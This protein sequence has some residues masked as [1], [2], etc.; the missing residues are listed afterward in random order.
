MDGECL[1]YSI[2]NLLHF[3]DGAERVLEIFPPVEGGYMIAETSKMVEVA[4]S[5]E[6][7]NCILHYNRKINLT[8][9][10]FWELYNFWGLSESV[11]EKFEDE[12]FLCFIFAIESKGTAHAV[13]AYF[14]LSDFTL[15]LMDSS[16]YGSIKMVE[17]SQFFSTM[18][19]HGFCMI[20]TEHESGR[21]I[22]YIVNRE[23]IKEIFE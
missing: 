18:K 3:C 15:I 19:V 16:G 8:D 23:I 22:P 20:L 11:R 5:G 1:P 4:S 9:K 14:S 6:L 17:L 13:S 2:A 10:Q 21:M 7:F 12:L